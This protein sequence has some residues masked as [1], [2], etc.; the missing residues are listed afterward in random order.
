MP[1]TEGKTGVQK[2]EESRDL[3]GGSTAGWRQNQNRSFQ[4]AWQLALKIHKTIQHRCLGAATSYT[5]ITGDQPQLHPDTG[6]FLVSPAP[7]WT[8][9]ARKAPLSRFRAQ[10][11]SRLGCVYVCRFRYVL[12]CLWLLSS[13]E[14]TSNF[15]FYYYLCLISSRDI[16]LWLGI[17]RCRIK[18]QWVHIVS[19]RVRET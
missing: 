17:C 10:A 8:K 18:R 14:K 3:P 1:R 13:W 19:S 6:F 16:Q 4:G 2:A 7:W 5:T 15:F 9:Q 11:L 12:W